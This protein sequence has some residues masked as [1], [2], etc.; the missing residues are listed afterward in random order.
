MYRIFLFFN[1]VTDPNRLWL[2][3]SYWSHY[4]SRCISIRYRIYFSLSYSISTVIWEKLSSIFLFMIL[5]WDNFVWQM[6]FF[7]ERF[8]FLSINVSW[9]H[10]LLLRK[11]IS[12]KKLYY[13]LICFHNHHITSHAQSFSFS[14]PCIVKFCVTGFTLYQ[15]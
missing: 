8:V 11:T 3:L 1:P 6:Y 14:F 5:F 10:A 13:T 2:I 15:R 4:G 7:F 12:Y 9:V